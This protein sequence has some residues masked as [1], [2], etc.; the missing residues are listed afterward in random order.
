MGYPAQMINYRWSADK[1]ERLKRTR[2]ISFER[3]VLQVER[4]NVLDIVEHPNQKKYPG[5]KYLIV[6]IDGYAH[7]IPFVQ[8]GDDRFLKTIIPS[9]KATKT[10]LRGE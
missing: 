8:H 6:D 1:N 7:L 2:G 9:R 3:I 4:G 5:Q 10:Y